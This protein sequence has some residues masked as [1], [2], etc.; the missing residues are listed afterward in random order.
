VLTILI[1]VVAILSLPVV[2][3]TCV[4]VVELLAAILPQ[5]RVASTA[6]DRPCCAV[7]IPAHNEES[8]IG[9][10]IAAIRPQLAAGDRILVVADNCTDATAGMAR[11]AGAEVVERTDAVRRGKGY[12][13]D[14]GVRA[15]AD[16]RPAVVVIVD[17]DCIMETGSLDQLVR[18]AASTGRP[19]QAAYEMQAPGDGGTRAQLAAFLFAL[20]NVIRPRGLSRLGLPCLLTG[21]GMALPWDLLASAPLASG[22]IVEDMQLGIDLALAG[23][24]PVFCPAACVRS[25]LPVAR[26]AAASQRTRWVHGHLRTLTSQTPRLLGAAIRQRR[27]D[28]LGLA[29]ELSVPPLSLLVLTA[30]IA[31]AALMAG[32]LL[33]GPRLPAAILVG[34]GMAGVAGLLLTWGS[35]G[36]KYL[37]VAGLLAVPRELAGRLSILLRFLVRPQGTWVRTERRNTN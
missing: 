30:I 28:L 24:P 15:L 13:L 16:K 10:T 25:E 17:A 11:M 33:G 7:L 36:R 12:A 19:A 8:G 23:K 26:A 5:R 6:N 21:T 2:V 20:K 37:P 18:T 35:F 29:L 9:C 3:A 27:F 22:N 34:V 1:W 31:A 4:L 32:W 14:Y